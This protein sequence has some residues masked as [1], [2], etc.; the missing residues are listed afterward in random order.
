MDSRRLAAGV[1]D[2]ERYNVKH[3]KLNDRINDILLLPVPPE[4]AG[5]LSG[6]IPE[7]LEDDP[8]NLLTEVFAA[9]P[10][11]QKD[12]LAKIIRIPGVRELLLKLADLGANISILTGVGL[13]PGKTGAM[14]YDR[15]TGEF[16][17]YSHDKLPV[18]Y[19]G[20]GDIFSSTCVGALSRGLDWKQAVQIAA[21][22]TAECIRL[23]LE[24]PAKPWYGVNFEQA[25]PYLVDRLSK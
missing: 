16:W 23:T 6:G 12:G 14:G 3:I 20:T 22:Y 4:E 5:G 19:H 15:R 9:I 11:I 13:A 21:D 8:Y 1:L 24:D 2:G 18:S 17:H 10:E 7:E 25:V